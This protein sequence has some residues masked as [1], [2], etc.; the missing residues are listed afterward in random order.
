MQNC[1]YVILLE[2]V[3][4]TGMPQELIRRHVAHVRDLS[5]KGLLIMCGP[6]TD[7]PGGVVII[8]AA[9]ATEANRMA[10]TDPFVIEGVR[11]FT[12]RTCLLAT[13]ENGFLLDDHR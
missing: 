3:P 1:A 2:T 13:P 8:R 12:V 7:F 4:G 11:T 6:C 10:A 5:E 9:D